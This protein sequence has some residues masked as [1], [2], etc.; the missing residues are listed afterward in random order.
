VRRALDAKRFANLIENR[1]AGLRHGSDEVR[2]PR[3]LLVGE[4]DRGRCG[5]FR[6]DAEANLARPVLVAEIARDAET[7]TRIVGHSWMWSEE[8][9]HLRP[10]RRC[11][12]G[13]EA[14]PALHAVPTVPARVHAPILSPCGGKL[15]PG[16]P[17]GTVA[18][19]QAVLEIDVCAISASSSIRGL[20]PCRRVD[21][22]GDRREG[23]R[24]DRR[25][26]SRQRRGDRRAPEGVARHAPDGPAVHYESR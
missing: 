8:L 2:K 5:V 1:P 19:V 15:N 23:P 10:L 16:Q 24:L 6:P 17:D 22:L 18:G 14:E 9:D 25:A 12:P 26:T 20:R 11:A 7:L 21:R 4:R 13:A 3:R